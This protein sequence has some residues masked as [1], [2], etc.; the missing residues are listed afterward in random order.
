VS[1]TVSEAKADSPLQAVYGPI[2]AE[3]AEVESILRAE[4]RSDH[5]Y[6]DELVRYG[7]LLGGKRLR[8]TLLLLA[9]KAVGEVT[10]EHLTLAAVVEMI[11][12]ATLVHDDVLDEA[13]TRRHLATVNSRW[14][15]KASVLLGDYLFTHAFYL[16]STTDSTWACREIGRATNIVCEG[17]LRQKGC[18][19][20]FALS[21]QEYLEIIAAKTAE[22]TAC[23]CRLGAYY[24]GGSEETVEK[25]TRFG[26]DLGIAFQIVDDVLDLQG[27]EAKTGKSLGTDLEQQKATLPIIHALQQSSETEREEK[28]ALLCSEAARSEQLIPWMTKHGSIQYAF[29]VA[30]KFAKRAAASLDCLDSGPGADTLRL[31][32]H[33]VLQRS[34]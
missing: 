15:N 5:P 10:S 30:R 4:L 11:H 27:D 29:D 7:C 25:M 31:V 21:E 1:R 6:V 26:L 9:A 34:H 16:A 12:T 13:E 23:S 18:R 28:L 24:A 20:D 17:E 33:F 14:D 3:L 32:A 22:L 2:E 8:P 19:G